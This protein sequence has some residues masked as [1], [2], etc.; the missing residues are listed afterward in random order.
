MKVGVMVSRSQSRPIRKNE[1][2]DALF[3]HFRNLTTAVFIIA[4][5]LYVAQADQHSDLAIPILIG[6]RAMGY[7][8]ATI[9]GGLVLINLWD[10]L[11][12]IRELTASLHII[13]WLVLA[14]IS[15]FVTFRVLQVLLQLRSS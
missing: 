1:L 4:A 8:V 3:Q 7:F 11:A 2:V 12:K 5:G 9:G 14:V 6:A 15:F 13:I 10:G